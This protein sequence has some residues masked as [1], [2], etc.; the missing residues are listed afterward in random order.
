MEDTDLKDSPVL[1]KLG[2]DVKTVLA[3]ANELMERH[4][5]EKAE[6]GAAVGDT[7]DQVAKFVTDMGEKVDKYNATVEKIQADIKAGSFRTGV[8]KSFG[9]KALETIGY[10]K[11]SKEGRENE[12]IGKDFKIGA[13][14]TFAKSADLVSDVADSAGDIVSQ[15]RDPN[16]YFEPQRQLSM[17]N[18]IPVIPIPGVCLKLCAK[19]TS[20]SRMKARDA[21]A[22]MVTLVRS[23]RSYRTRTSHSSISSCYASHRTL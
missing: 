18:L 11:Y 22:R 2:E 6:L 10:E 5:K 9:Q 3:K 20:V 12:L 15:T 21:Q 23:F 19:P 4:D 13:G 1:K 16:I 17:R 14:Q 8:A 7:K